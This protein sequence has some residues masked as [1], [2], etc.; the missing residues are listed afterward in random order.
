MDKALGNWE[1][2][3][4]VF[5]RSGLPYSVFSSIDSTGT[6]LSQRAD[7]GNGTDNIVLPSGF[8]ADPTL[9]TGPLASMFAQPCPVG[10]TQVPG[11]CSGT[12]TIPRQGNV[13]RNSFFGPGFREVDFSVIKRFPISDRIK[14]RLQADFFNLFNN[15]NFD[16]PVNII[17]SPQFGQS[18]TT[19]GLPRVIQFAF[20]IDF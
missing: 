7:L 6:G 12:S 13:G 11:G 16:N 9:Q 3:S 17:T 8:T 14:L 19:L 18:I 4:I 2:S 10:A 1:L 5:L 20:R 15:A